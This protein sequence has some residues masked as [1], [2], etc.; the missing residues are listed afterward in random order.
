MILAYLDAFSEVV[1]GVTDADF[2]I[3]VEVG[4]KG[5]SKDS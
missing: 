1:N 5:S 2:G 4:V 3:D